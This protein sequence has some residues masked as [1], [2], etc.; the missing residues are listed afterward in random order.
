MQQKFQTVVAFT[1]AVGRV[2]RALKISNAKN[3]YVS[4][5]II[6]IYKEKCPSLALSPQTVVN[7]AKCNFTTLCRY[8]IC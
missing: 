2:R 6:Q 3:F 8:K 5:K 4:S 1:Q 7:M